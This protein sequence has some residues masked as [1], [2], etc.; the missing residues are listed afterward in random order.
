[1]Q[2]ERERGRGG[3][4]RDDARVPAEGRV[5]LEP[6]REWRIEPNHTVFG[7]SPRDETTSYAFDYPRCRPS[8]IFMGGGLSWLEFVR[9]VEAIGAALP[10]SDFD[11]E[12]HAANVV[13]WAAR[14]DLDDPALRARFDLLAEHRVDDYATDPVSETDT[15]G[16]M[17]VSM[18]PGGRIG[19]HEHPRQSGL[20]ACHTGRV[21]VDAFDVLEDPLRLRRVFEGTLGAGDMASLT[22]ARGNVHRLRSLEETFLIDVFTPP[23]TEAMRRSCRAFDLLEEVEPGVFSVE[24]RL[25]AAHPVEDSSSS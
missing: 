24:Q 2:N 4:Q 22:P 3:H 23:A 10:D 19:L 16:V 21:R 12:I 14:L 20:M 11:P 25:W 5:A 6:Q 15:I 1:M 9:G 17:L 8:R 18:K 7:S 13:A